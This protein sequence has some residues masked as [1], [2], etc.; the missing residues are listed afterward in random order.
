MKFKTGALVVLFSLIAVLFA[1]QDEIIQ[2]SAKTLSTSFK[3]WNDTIPEDR[4][5][6]QCDKPFYN[7]G[8]TIWFSVFIRDAATFKASSKS[9]IVYAEL[10]NPKGSVEKM[11]T[12]IAKKGIASGDFTIADDLPGGLYTLKAYSNWQKNDPDPAFFVKEIQ[13]QNVVLPR[14]KMKLDFEKK[15]YGPGAH[16]A[17]DLSLTTNENKPLGTFP[18]TFTVSVAG[19]QVFQGSSKTDDA[20]KVKIAFDLPKKLTSSDGLLN[21]LID[22]DGQTESISRSI[23]IV[24]NKITLSFFPEGGDLVSGL[25]STVAFKAVNEFGKA[26]DIEGYIIDNDSNK[27]ESFQSF[28]MGMGGFTFEPREGKT[29][30]ARITRP[31]G[32]SELYPLPDAMPQGYVLHVDAVEKNAL[33]LSI[34]STR[35]E[36]LL[37]FLQ[38]RGKEYFSKE[39][40]AKKGMDDVSIDITKFPAGVAQVTLFDSKGIERAERLVFLNKHRKA[41]VTIKTD[42][43]RYMPREK[44]KLTITASDET[45]MRMPG[46]FALAVTDDQLLSFADDKSSTI[47]SHM[48]AE[49]DIKGKVEEPRFYFDPE[50]QKS[51][52]ALDFLLMTNGWRRFTWKQIAEDEMPAINNP[53]ERAI[54]AGKVMDG[55]TLKPIPGAT[56][57]VVGTK[58]EATSDSN[59]CFT[60]KNVDL[61]ETAT[62][63]SAHGKLWG[64]MS[65][66]Q[67]S[68]SLELWLYGNRIVG[69][70][71][72][73]GFGGAA[74][75]LEL[76]QAPMPAMAAEMVKADAVREKVNEEKRPLMRKNALPPP[77]PPQAMAKANKPVPVQPAMPKADEAKVVMKKRVIK[78][79]MA[80][81]MVK[82][83]RFAPEIIP[84]PQPPAVSYYRAREYAFPDYKTQQPSPVRTDF[85]STIFWKGDVECKNNGTAVVE[86][87]TS[88]AITSFRAITEGF[89]TEGSIGRAEEV[90]YSQLPFSIN[91]KIPPVVLTGDTMDLSLIIK[92]TTASVLKGDLSFTIPDGLKLLNSVNKNRTVAASGTETVPVKL[93]VESRNDSASISFTFDAG[94]L[95]DAFIAPVKIKPQGFPVDLSFSGSELKDKFTVNITGPVKNSITATFRAYPSAVSDLLTGIESILQEPYGC[96]EQTSM[97]SY[98]NALVLSYLKSTDTPD[99]DIVKRAEDLLQKGYSRLTTFETKDKGYEWFGGVP[100]HEALTA[101]GLMQFHD[102]NQIGEIAD[103][104]MIDR[105][106][107]WIMSR[108]DNKGGF[109]RNP[110]ALDSYGGADQDITNAY[111]V[112]ALAEAGRRDIQKELDASEKSAQ[113]SKDPYVLALVANALFCFEDSQRG[114][115]FLKLLMSK[116]DK[117]GSWCGTRHSITRSE[118]IGLKLETT[119]L[120]CLAIMSSRQGDNNAL[121]NGIKFIVKSR[122]GSGGFGSTQSTIMSLKALTKYAQFARKTDAPGTI[123]VSVNDKDVAKKSYKAGEKEAIV[124]DSL[125]KFVK[126][127]SST[128][129]IRYE[130]TKTALPYSLAVSYNTWQP[131][132][133]QHCK[134]ELKTSVSAA[135]VKIGQTAR[136]TAVLTNKTESGLPMTLAIVGIPAGL[137]PQP[138]Q[139]KEL[140][141]KKIVDFY[142]VNGSE[143]VFYYRQM[144]P[145]EERTINLDCKAEV[146]GTFTP[147][148]SRAYLYYTN[149]DKVWVGMKPVQVE[150]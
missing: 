30:L 51:D 110:Q 46:N 90:F 138:W 124:I 55:F 61:Y 146:A 139:L 85:R 60:F 125:E 13:V 126:E 129:A 1:K 135:K 47:L 119:S 6:V 62:L 104:A 71:F 86:F 16:A 64:Q 96:F 131:V 10:I 102:M 20:G 87:Y 109:Q 59:G 74:V 57:K 148:A 133:S 84:E 122:D 76:D 117:D 83:Q 88:D 149:E 45:G 143:V 14:L 77:A 36:K 38:I 130:G 35:E 19:A 2:F 134:V 144:K 4:I 70:G 107:N 79:E 54:I 101:Y 11:L 63:E 128:I 65:V 15:A 113:E 100:A 137:S 23:P 34:G 106:A 43:Q 31:S 150:R 92:N 108:R 121:V 32:I 111:I 142:E 115:E 145:S 33:K 56:V 39:I 37:V 80:V 49:S 24:L 127:G 18:V 68:S 73:A 58:V 123:I 112:Y 94:G 136:I 98:P 25:K 103:K 114:N 29:Y 50:E 22:Y 44:V 75:D 99:P 48:L 147:A 27:I 42:K 28:H 40:A 95:S 91:A 140:Q 8:E 105:T 21:V 17:A 72:G 89:T 132:S 26:A 9:D 7:P 3:K 93:L 41:S 5:Y 52:K 82:Q 12:L 97:T 69:H 141:E 66:G 53:S 118:G 120:V 81:D 78:D 67:Y 116:Q